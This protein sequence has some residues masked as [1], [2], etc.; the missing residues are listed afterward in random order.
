MEQE[1]QAGR[2]ANL[3]LQKLAVRRR[4]STAEPIR[5]M[6]CA[7]HPAALRSYAD[8][9]SGLR[10]EDGRRID[11]AEASDEAGTWAT[12]LTV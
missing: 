1:Q 4:R 11:A 7:L 10:S 8:S 6:R 5:P 9:D 2:V 3:E 12:H